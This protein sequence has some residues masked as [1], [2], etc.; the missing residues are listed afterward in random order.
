MRKRLLSF[1]LAVLMIASLL[2]AAVLAADIVDSGTCGAEGDGSNLTWMLDSKGALT[3]RGTGEMA[4]YGKNYRDA[5]LRAPWPKDIKTVT[6]ENGVTSIG[7]Y[8]FYSC[9]ELAA[10]TIPDS[11]TSIGMSAFEDCES[12]AAITIP[13]GVTRISQNAFSSCRNLTD[14]VIPKS[15]TSI[16]T[17]AFYYCRKLTAIIIP[18]NVTSIENRAFSACDA[19]KDIYYAG[20]EAQWTSAITDRAAAG[21]ADSVTIHCNYPYDAH[22]FC[23]W[24]VVS[25]ATCTVPGVEKRA[26]TDAGC[27]ETQSREIAAL[28]HDWDWDHAVITKAATETE[29]GE[30]TYTCTRCGGTKV[31]EIPALTTESGTC[32][33]NLTWTLDSEKTLT[34][35]GTGYM[36]FEGMSTVGPWGYSVKK[37]II[38]EGVLNIDNCAFWECVDLESV[39]LPST[40]KSIGDKAFQYCTSLKEITIPASVEEMDHP[41]ISCESLQGFHVAADNPNYCDVNG[42][43]MSKDQTKLYFYPLGR[44]DTSYTVPSTVQSIEYCSF[45]DSQMLKTVTIP[46]T[47]KKIDINAFMYSKQL[48]QV[49]LSTGL[50]RIGT[51]AF[52]FCPELKT[53]TI[54][55]S[56]E[57]DYEDWHD[58]NYCG[59]SMFYECESLESVVFQEGVTSIPSAFYGAEKLKTVSIP[60]TVES[61]STDFSLC[62]KLEEISV[63][64]GNANFCSVNG[65]LFNKDRS[66]LL[67]YP[68]GKA[69]DSY[70]IPDTVIHIGESA[71]YG[72]TRLKTVSIPASVSGVGRCA[73]G[74]I[75]LKEILV[76]EQNAAF[77]S[78]DGVLFDK[79]K[80]ELIR[81]P[82]G[83]VAT[84]YQI[85][86]SVTSV[87]DGAFTYCCHLKTI[88]IPKGITEFTDWVFMC[89]YNL[90][91]VYYT[92]TEAQW[93]AIEIGHA[94]D[95]LINATKHYNAE[96][97][98]FGAWTVTK[99]ATCTETGLRTRACTDAGCSKVETAVIPALGHTEAV[100]A[101]KA[102]TCTETGLTEGKHC[103]V[104]G[105]ILTVQEKTD[106]LGHAWDNGKVTKEPTETETGVK[107]FT[108][109]RCGETKTEVIPALSHEHNYNAVV[110][111]PTCTAKGYTTHTC[112]CGDSYVDTY[113]DALGHAW[114]NGKVTKPATETEDGVKTFTCTRC[115]ETKTETI[116]KLTHEHSY[117]AVVTAPTCTA[118]GYTTHTC[119]CGDSYVDA[120][121]DALGHA[122]D[123][124]KVTKAATETES[125]VKTFTCTRCGETKTEVI[126]ATG[127]VDVTEMFTDVS[128][129]WADDGI[130]YCVTHQLMSGIGN[131]LFGPKLTTTRAQIVQ[132][133]Y[134]LE[135]E[136][137]VSGTTPFTDLTQDWYQDAILW[138][139]QTGVVAG[140]GDGT[141][142]E[143]DRPVTREQIAVILMEYVTRVLKLERTW[144]P[145]DLSAFPDAGSVSDWAKDAMAD[146]VALGLISGAS[147]GG[148]TLLEPQ[149]SATR[150]QVATILMEFCKNVKK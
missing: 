9:E 50:E 100:D 5:C 77:C 138:A 36:R 23:G 147:N 80:T 107:T 45:S 143:P 120:Y 35:S 73:F 38:G 71:F 61:M 79:G 39:Q 92:G 12:L 94:N 51:F 15:V 24:T 117:D 144:T 48:Q 18:G 17:F 74:G 114:D 96:I 130:R 133:L 102:A 123:E 30:E 148:Q 76:D 1:V 84:S 140:T 112:A 111:A 145:A 86:G 124:G 105:A 93:N 87:S 149:G 126:P 95:A 62:G 109:T 19:L 2:P 6:I 113:V 137:E 75:S 27:K 135:G 129:S 26:C 128:H 43:L 83:K 49:S 101:A 141:T 89:C 150:E 10:I 98:D 4:H 119:A 29:A 127:S 21:I 57:F 72:C 44:P 118:K 146:A 81:Y 28:G 139:Y 104:C 3:I 54:P 85:P 22:T 8:A 115:G 60:S 52:A 59:G 55:G 46:G 41:F 99:A 136:P 65:I 131:N 116:P 13:D 69:A 66:E 68:G 34:V 58:Q 56:V 134:N 63:A 42:V 82:A 64:D 25:A 97:H 91:D 142:F 37:A 125:G 132:I 88:A 11:V 90:E 121:T 40:L 108:C 70:R 103:S 7:G 106:A 31:E 47:V 20:S 67:V 122:W 110:T 16:G 32:G 53:M 14:I 78:T 33:E